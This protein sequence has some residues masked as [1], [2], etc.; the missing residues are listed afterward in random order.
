MGP[1]SP[2]AVEK[3]SDTP[4]AL[5][6]RHE[7]LLHSSNGDNSYQPGGLSLPVDATEQSSPLRP[8]SSVRAVPNGARI[9]KSTR[10]ANYHGPSTLSIS[11][12]GF[13]RDFSDGV[14]EV[15]QA[16]ETDDQVVESDEIIQ[17]ERVAS[18]NERLLCTAFVSFLSFALLQLSFAAVAQS[19][20][21]MGD[22]AAMIVDAM[23]YLF[24][25]IA[26]RRKNH[27][28]SLVAGLANPAR[29]RR[30]LELHMEIIPPLISVV[31]LV[32][33]IIL[34]LRRSIRILILDQ[35]RSRDQQGN[36]NVGLMMI[37]SILNLFL[38]ALNVFCFAQAK[39]LTGFSVTSNGE[40]LDDPCTHQK[41]ATHS[42][43]RHRGDQNYCEVDVQTSDFDDETGIELAENDDSQLQYHNADNGDCQ[44][45]VNR[46]AIHP[47][48]SAAGS[49]GENDALFRTD[50]SVNNH[51]N[52]NMC[53]AF[54][55]VFADTLR[56][57]AV[58]VAA[59]F[60]ELF[61]GTLT[62]EEADATA[63]VVVSVLI[64]LSLLPLVKGL[65]SS[66]SELRLILAEERS[67]SIV[68]IS[69]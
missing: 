20:A 40:S 64:L 28:D 10:A 31:T 24:N 43:H 19:Q 44:P 49:Q 5:N 27:L 12:D 17:Q 65:W 66:L 41:V 36:P 62:P 69:R 56:S 32:I 11:T 37:F 38:D 8:S 61:P 9:E 29:T 13:P 15:Q 18:T 26:E 35:H 7:H 1:S 67:E 3:Y 54:T 46:R 48:P 21:M 33:V 45:P 23:T 6:V 47:F 4:V 50:A 57:I 42:A 16:S 51:A 60:S 63:A 52:L 68:S 25:W 53:S 2:A 22:A 39:H 58:I 55:H 14:D 34:V 59:L 30:K